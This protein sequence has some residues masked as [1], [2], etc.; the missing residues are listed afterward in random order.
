MQATMA[1]QQRGVSLVEICSI[2]GV[3]TLHV[4][5]DSG[6]ADSDH[7]P[8]PAQHAGGFECSLTSVLAGAGLPAALPAMLRHAPQQ[9]V[10]AL[11]ASVP[12]LPVDAV[13]R[14]LA[15]RLHA[16]PMSV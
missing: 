7:A 10:V 1:A 12:A 14:W 9:Y 3:R 15:A 16:P 4:D 8:M 2:Y 6:T 5:A 11:P 13:Q